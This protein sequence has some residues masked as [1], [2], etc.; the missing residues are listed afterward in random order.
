MSAPTR[1]I[2]TIAIAP[3]PSPIQNVFNSPAYPVGRLGLLLPQRLDHPHHETGINLADRHLAEDGG[4]VL[5]E[6]IDPLRAV[7]DIFSSGS[8]RRDVG[9]STRIECHRLGTR[10]RCSSSGFVAR[11]DWVYSLPAQLSRFSGLLTCRGEPD[12]GERTEPHVPFAAD[13]R[14]AE[15]PRSIDRAVPARCRLQVQTT[16]VGV[17]SGRRILY[18]GRRQFVELA[19][20]CTPVYTPVSRG[21][22]GTSPDTS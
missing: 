11:F 18:L 17:P 7:F 19:W 21:Y 13:Q 4:N 6:G 1:R 9:C 8:M 15:Y 3:G 22:R 14:E 16:A 10:G 12:I 2:L 20:H 5:C